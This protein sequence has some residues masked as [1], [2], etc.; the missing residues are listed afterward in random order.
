MLRLPHEVSPLFREWL[1]V[2]YPDRAGKVMGI[3]QSV[4]E[5]KDNDPGFF[6]RMKPSGVWADVFRTRFRIATK[7]LGMNE[8]RMVLDRTKFVR[9]S[10]DGQLRLL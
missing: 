9:P 3:V 1:E 10:L 4:R 5:G 8:E 6:T 2:H 7:R